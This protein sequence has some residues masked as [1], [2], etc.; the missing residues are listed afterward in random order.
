[1]NKFWSVTG[2]ILLLAIALLLV[3]NSHGGI[4]F[5]DIETEC[6]YDRTTDYQISLQPDNQLHFRGHF[7]VNSTKAD[8][9]Y[10]YSQ[11]S[12]KIVLN[13][14]ARDEKEAPESF[15][16]QC[17]GS[18][19]YDGVTSSLQEGFYDVILKHDGVRVE[20]QVISIE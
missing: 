14:I 12:N 17:L 2:G 7:P 18:V 3:G 11:G 9:S 15:R 13:V 4:T 8:L 1:M 6:R 19:V 10:K 16:N 5:S 20:H